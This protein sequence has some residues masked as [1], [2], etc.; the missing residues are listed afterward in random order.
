M[1]TGTLW[2]F[3]KLDGSAL[4]IDRTEYSVEPV[5]MIL[6]ILLHCIGGDPATAG[7]AA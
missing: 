4:I 6:A 2:R 7:A 1:T 5:G 3:L